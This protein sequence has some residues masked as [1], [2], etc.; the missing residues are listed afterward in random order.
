MYRLAVDLVE[1]YPLLCLFIAVAIV[2]T[3]RKQPE[4]RGR[5][6]WIAV[7][8][9]ILVILSLPFTGYL[10]LGSLEWQY[11][12]LAKVPEG[13][14]ALVVLAGAVRAPVG[15]RVELG[16]STLYRCLLAA[17]LYRQADGCPVIA[18]GGDAG[19]GSPGLTLAGAMREFLI[20]QGV[21]P[22]DV[23]AEDQ[24]RTTLENASYTAELLREREIS[25]IVLVTS[26][27]HLPRAVRCFR[28]Q[29][30]TV[31][32]TGCDYRA[33]SYGW[34]SDGLFP[35]T[36][37]LGK[38]HEAWHEWLGMAWYAVRGRM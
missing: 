11:P 24:S 6:V 17:E 26:A 36:A 16:D 15:E 25:Q 21:P 20:R 30:L 23:L 1:P 19:A 35:S 8:F 31:T 27:S 10:A 9:S 18:S 32:P 34:R 28:A 22:S 12:P 38:V 2:W 33:T 4:A 29:G 3:W 5:L 14:Q 7:P 37:A 13:T